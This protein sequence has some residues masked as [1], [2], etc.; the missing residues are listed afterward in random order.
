VDAF[1]ADPTEFLD[2]DGDGVGNNA[3][4]LPFDPADAVDADADGFGPSTDC[5]DGDPTVSPGASEVP[6]NG[7]DDD[8]QPLTPDDDLDGDGFGND[9]DCDDRNA[10]AAPGLTEIYYNG[11]DEDC[12]PV[13]ND[14]DFDNDGNPIQLDCDDHNPARGTHL[15][16]IQYNDVDEN[17]DPTDDFDQDGDGIP[18]DQ[19]VGGAPDCDDTDPVLSTLLNGYLD[20][21]L[22]GT[23][24]TTVAT[25]LCTDGALPLAY[26]AAGGA[27]CD[28]ND[29]LVSVIV[30]G[31]PDIDQ[32]GAAADL[33]STP[34]CTDGSLPAGYGPVRGTDCDDDDPAVFPGASDPIDGIDTNCDG[35][36]GPAFFDDFDT[37]AVNPGVFASLTGGVATSTTYEVSGA[38]S[39]RFT[40][41]GGT[42]ETYPLDVSFCTALELV[43]QVKR[44]SEAPDAG[45]DLVF[46]VLLDDGTELEVLRSE[47]NGVT[48]LFEEFVVPITDPRALHSGLVLRII[49]VGGTGST[50]DYYFIDDLLLHCPIDTDGDGLTDL[51]EGQLGTD[52]NLADTDSDGIDDGEEVNVYGS[53]PTLVDSDADGLDDGDEVNTH[54]TDPARADTD[55]DGLDDADE[56]NV[57]GTDPTDADSD[58]DGYVDGYEIQ[59]GT[60]PLDDADV[61]PTAC[62]VGTFVASV[63]ATEAAYELN[64]ADLANT[65]ICYLPTGSGYDIYAGPAPGFPAPPVGGTAIT[66][67]EAGSTTLTLATPVPFYGADYSALYLSGNGFMSFD[68]GESD[69]TDSAFGMLNDHT[70]TAW[71]WNDL[72]AP[73]VGSAWSWADTGDRVVVHLDG[74]NNNGFVGQ[75]Q[76]EIVRGS[77]EILVTYGTLDGTSFIAGISPATGNGTQVD[78]IP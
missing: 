17:C 10:S 15:P 48:T 34:L 74:M 8:C 13:T 78:F 45:E 46:T 6:Y 22:D 59:Q 76:I 51:A 2:S 33:P 70:R 9:Q 56:I 67:I 24:V 12:D 3:D 5:D 43:V 36:D 18:S 27:D 41:V 31:F 19:A 26:A 63:S 53:D 75:T 39:L 40:G 20:A 55:H 69:P 66:P 60:D 16:E 61:P 71:Y 28:D 1:P 4:A 7:T 62:Q 21:D 38:Y 49:H 11:V 68:F 72:L 50:F 44:G 30:N 14:Q 32:D 35:A 42:A 64:P 37:G 25:P 29:A 54:G 77:G 58:D 23:A 52:P 47:G 65:Q 57:H 73:P